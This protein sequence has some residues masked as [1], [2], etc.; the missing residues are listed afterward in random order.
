M[1]AMPGIAERCSRRGG[2]GRPESAVTMGT[3]VTCFAGREGREP[4]GDHGEDHRRQDHHPGQVEQADQVV[5]GL[6]HV[7]PVGDPGHQAERSAEQRADEPDRQAVRPHHPPD[8]A[9]GR[10]DRGEHADG[11][12]PSVGEHGEAPDGDQPDQEHADGGDEDHED[13]GVEAAVE[14]VGRDL[15]ARDRTGLGRRGVE[16]QGGL[17]VSAHLPRWDERELVQE[18]LGVLDD[19]HHVPG[20]PGVMPDASH[21]QTE[22]GGHAA[23]DGHLVGCVR[24]APA[25]QVQHRS[26]VGARRILGPQVVG[27]DRSRDGE[28]LVVDHV[29]RADP[30]PDGCD[31]RRELRV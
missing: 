15:H 30:V 17:A 6:L 3:R 16:Q 9:V 1:K 25:G 20:H 2:A 14:R 23:R 31:G 7:R 24:V 29:D 10:A 12:H 5:G 21:V 8:V 28:H 11:P 19:A 27:G 13:L 22:R 26:A 4:G 18:V